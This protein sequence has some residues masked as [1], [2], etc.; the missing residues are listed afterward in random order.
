MLGG[1]T[2]ECSSFHSPLQEGSFQLVPI[3]LNQFLNH[4]KEATMSIGCKKRSFHCEEFTITAETKA[5]LHVAT[6]VIPSAFFPGD[7]VDFFALKD[8]Y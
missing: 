1:S 2:R 6:I 8:R 4:N 7:W 5:G 3:L